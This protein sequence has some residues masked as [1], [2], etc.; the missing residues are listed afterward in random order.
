MRTL[1]LANKAEICNLPGCLRVI[2]SLIPKGPEIT[3]D[4]LDDLSDDEL[5]TA[6]IA[7][8]AIVDARANGSGLPDGWNVAI[9][10]LDCRGLGDL[11]QN[12]VA[13]ELRAIV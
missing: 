8:P 13:D 10:S 2:A 9:T 5:D 3:Q 12:R 11:F 4:P 6:I 7:V 1:R